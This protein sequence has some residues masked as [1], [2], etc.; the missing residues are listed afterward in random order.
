MID[1]I[2]K[3]AVAAI[4]E[5]LEGKLLILDVLAAISTRRQPARATFGWNRRSFR[6]LARIAVDLANALV[7]FVTGLQTLRLRLRREF[8]TPVSALKLFALHAV[9]HTL[10]LQILVGEASATL[11]A[12][13][14]AAWAPSLRW[15]GGRRRR[16]RRGPRRRTWITIAVNRVRALLLRETLSYTVDFLLL[17]LAWAS[18]GADE[19]VGTDATRHAKNADLL[20]GASLA[21][22]QAR[23][24]AA[25]APLFR[26]RYFLLLA[27]LLLK[28]AG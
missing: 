5:T 11:N 4:V 24:D 25:Q 18:A 27:G 15:F 9:D 26:H 3:L 10:G 7:H 21:T 16:S 20:R 28:R 23:A 17:G 8:A 1:A 14:D 6:F 22:V 19:V 2:E 12:G 13:R